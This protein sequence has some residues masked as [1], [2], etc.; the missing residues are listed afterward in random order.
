LP[1]EP[2]IIICCSRYL[3]DKWDNMD[4]IDRGTYQWY[5]Y[6][7]VPPALS[8]HQSGNSIYNT[9]HP[10][11]ERL[12]SQL[13]IEAASPYTSIP[14]DYRMSQIWVEGL[15]GKVPRL[16]PK[17]LI[18]EEGHQI[19][20]ANNTDMF[21]RWAVA[22]RE[23]KPFKYST[24]MANYAAT[25]LLPRHLGEEHLVHGAKFY[26]PWEPSISVT[27]VVSGLVSPDSNSDPP[28]RR[29]LDSL[30][31]SIDHPFSEVV[32]ILPALS[33]ETHYNAKNLRSG[34]G[35]SMAVRTE[36][37]LAGVTRTIPV[38]TQRREEGIPAFMDL[39]QVNVDT[40]WFMIATADHRV[41]RRVN[42]MFTPGTFRPVV[43]FT[44]A[45]YRFCFS[46][47]ACRENVILAERFNP[48]HYRVVEDLD[49]LFHVGA[50]NEFCTEW[51]GRYGTTGEKLYSDEQGK[52]DNR[53]RDYNKETVAPFGP[54]A[55]S[56][57]AYLVSKQYDWM[58]KLADGS[59]YGARP[60]F[61]LSNGTGGVDEDNCLCYLIDEE[62][63]C[64]R[65]AHA[66]GCVWRPR[67]ETCHERFSTLVGR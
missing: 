61:L 14:Y 50:V 4:A 38:R 63:R 56:Y 48:G 64:L 43:P 26:S 58:Y 8:D 7:D 51:K 37:R 42:L 40:D 15:T 36:R 5:H 6:D 66:C 34:T 41:R 33:N 2:A 28:A 55:T 49:M 21:Q 45:T 32:V 17:I 30:D 9:S 35:G 46:K 39:C 12:V 10:L 44:P 25:N 24:V 1:S 67:F 31:R 60:A 57:L 62:A 47:N 59:L 16:P 18:N 20:L 27:L 11:L 65:A 13:E 22:W 23:K 52:E 54:T 19:Q 29:L 53:E 3:G